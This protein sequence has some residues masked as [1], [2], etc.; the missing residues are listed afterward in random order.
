MNRLSDEVRDFSFRLSHVLDEIGVNKRTVM[1]RRR[2]GL[3]MESL[4]T[5]KDY[6]ISKGDITHF[7][8]GSQTEGTTTLGLNADRDTLIC[9]NMYKIIQ[10]WRQWERGKANLLMLRDNVAPGYC[11]LQVLRSDIAAAWEDLPT[12][13]CEYDDEGRVLVKNTLFHNDDMGMIRHGPASSNAYLNADYVK[14]LPC[15]SWPTEALPWVTRAA[16]DTWSDRNLK[17]FAV[18]SGCFV[19]PTGHCLSETERLEWRISTSLAERCVMFNMNITQIKCYVVLKMIMKAFLND[20]LT[21]YQCKTVLMHLVEII[22]QE[23]WMEENLVSCIMMSLRL[24][25]LCVFTNNCPHYFI[26]ENNLLDGR[27]DLETRHNVVHAIGNIIDSNC[28]AILGIKIDNIGL[29]LFATYNPFNMRNN[30]FMSPHMNTYRVVH[31]DL[32]RL[33]HKYFQAMVDRFNTSNTHTLNFDDMK[34]GFRKVL[35]FRENGSCSDRVAAEMTAPLLCTTM[36]TKLA[37]ADISRGQCISAESLQWLSLGIDSDVASGRLK[38]ASVLFC[39]GDIGKASVILNDVEQRYDTRTTQPICACDSTPIRDDMCDL[40]FS[41]N[42]FLSNDNKTLMNTNVAFGV[43]FTRDEKR[44]VSTALQ[45]EMFR[46][47]EEEL[48]TRDKH[49]HWIDW[50]VVDSLPYL[51]YLQYMTY[52]RLDNHLGQQRALCRLIHTIDSEPSLSHRET[53]LN[54]LGQCMELEDRLVDAFTCYKRSLDMK[55]THNVA[56]WHV[57]KLLYRFL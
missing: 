48:R 40:R 25:Q 56:R 5:L 23:L 2:T 26:P 7:Y 42:C 4:Y 6:V 28:I 52:R 32:Y 53:A 24:L 54:L 22:S 44:C 16:E 51:Y 10:D 46:C 13:D 14:G 19:V 15:K 45:Y 1:M 21:S 41:D 34:Y 31:Y 18:N 49:C 11:R 17:C 39:S 50:A 37:S 36:G 3:L 55:P 38:L 47:T 35:Q 57:V 27:L 30:K 43:V 20:I 29:R 8:F 33:F 9:P 12:D